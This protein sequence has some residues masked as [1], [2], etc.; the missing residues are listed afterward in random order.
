MGHLQQFAGRRFT[1][2][3]S[4]GWNNVMPGKTSRWS[5]FFNQWKCCIS[6][7]E[8]LFFPRHLPSLYLQ[9]S[10]NNNDNNI[11]LS[12]ILVKCWYVNKN[13]KTII[14]IWLTGWP[15]II[16]KWD[17]TLMWLWA[18]CAL[19]KVGAMPEVQPMLDRSHQK[20]QMKNVSSINNTYRNL[21]WIG[22]CLGQQGP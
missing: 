18:L 1:D 2:S 3:I 11:C 4:R 14:N 22:H 20:K 17:N 19:R 21:Y 16:I 12:Q 13:A 6:A 5:H 7:L 15:T 9:N 8:L 10:N